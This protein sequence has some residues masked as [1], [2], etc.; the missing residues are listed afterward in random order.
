LL[1]ALLDDPFVMSAVLAALLPL[2]LSAIFTGGLGAISMRAAGCAIVIAFVIAHLAIFGMPPLPPRSSLQKIAYAA[3]LGLALGIALEM[4]G[5]RAPVKCIA[6]AWPAVIVIWLGWQ[7]LISLEPLALLRLALVYCAGAFVLDRLLVWRDSDIVVPSMLL[8][9]GLGACGVAFLGA[10]ASLSQLAAALAAATG[11]FL[12]WNWPTRRHA[13]SVAAVFGAG[14]AL[15]ATAAATA[16][17]TRANDTALAMLVLVFAAGYL[18]DKLPL[19]QG[20]ALRGLAFGA[21]A[22]LPALAAVALAFFLSSP[23]DY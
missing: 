5:S 4:L 6:R 15:F 17:F 19:P 3:V 11:G 16:L 13:L 18:R 10:A 2:A 20:P 22:L 8:V 1:Q 21:V 7:Q 12:L 9:A 14:S 23:A